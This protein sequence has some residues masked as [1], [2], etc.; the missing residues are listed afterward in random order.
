[1]KGAAAPRVAAQHPLDVGGHRERRGRPRAVLEAQA[2]DL[3]RVVERHE[4]EQLERDAV[5]LVLEAAVPLAVA[6]DVRPVVPDGQ[7]R[8][9]PDLARLLVA[10]VDRLAR[11]G[12]STGSLDQA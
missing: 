2:R 3:D 11:A 1:M 7:R 9:P 5:A 12:R 4:L 10:H 8:R 6:G